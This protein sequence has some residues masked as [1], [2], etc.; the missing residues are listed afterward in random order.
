MVITKSPATLH[1]SD[2]RVVDEEGNGSFKVVGLRLEVGVENGDVLAV[3]DVA[4]FQ[5]FFQCSCFV[6]SSGFSDLVS[7]VDAF[8]CPSQAFHLHHV[9]IDYQTKQPMWWNSM[10][11]RWSLVE[12]EWVCRVNEM[13]PNYW[14]EWYLITHLLLHNLFRSRDKMVMGVFF[15]GK[16]CR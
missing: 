4:P 9:L 16:L 12:C 7:Y 10:I 5:A 13:I 2:I 8:G 1:E 6:P 14:S 3:F 11:W 15:F